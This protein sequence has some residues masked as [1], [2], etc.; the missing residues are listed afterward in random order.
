M[1]NP[2]SRKCTSLQ[3]G[4][5]VVFWFVPAGYTYARGRRTM[6]GSVVFVDEK[7]RV[8]C[9]SYMEGYKERHEDVAFEDML[10]VHNPYAPT[11]KFEN[12]SGRSDLLI[13]E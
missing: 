5:K 12:I 8:V 7:R 6:N 1:N 10:A 9:V 13:P 11:M 2:L 3:S 4:E